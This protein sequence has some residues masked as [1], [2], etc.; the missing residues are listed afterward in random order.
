MNP[1]ARREGLLVEPLED[2]VLVYDL[3]R[4]RAHCLNATA[5]FVWEHCD[6]ERDVGELCR[7][8]EEEL[9]SPA[10]PEIVEL[11]LDRLHRARLLETAPA[12]EMPR[13]QTRRQA[14]RRMAKVGIAL[15]LVM[16][17][18]TPL[19]AQAATQISAW[20]CWSD[21]AGNRGK[22]CSNGRKCIQ[23]F[24]WG[25]CWGQTC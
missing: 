11:A 19:P 18:V 21:P 23:W 13:G 15:P 17:I 24:G 8:L 12:R 9:G 10:T 16:T 25:L 2:E 20:D 3:E 22:C 6:G 1:R 7:L 14:I 4:H 5:A